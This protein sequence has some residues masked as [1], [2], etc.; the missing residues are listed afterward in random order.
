[1][2][3]SRSDRVPI[4][5]ASDWEWLAGCGQ[6]IQRVRCNVSDDHSVV[7]TSLSMPS[8]C[9]LPLGSIFHAAHQLADAT[10]PNQQA[11]NFRS[12]YGPKV[13]GASALHGVGLRTKL[14]FFNVY[15]SAAGLMGSAGQAPH[16][17]SC[18]WLD[19]MAVYRRNLGL[20]GQSVSWVRSRIS[21]TPHGMQGR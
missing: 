16:S 11:L 21:A 2:L 18:T 13:F 9:N 20:T 4:E 17:A 19:V 3:S 14:L 8:Y 7:T 6:T 5:S 1:M 15:S 10:I 12:A